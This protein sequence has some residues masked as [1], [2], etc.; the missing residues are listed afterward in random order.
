[1]KGEDWAMLAAAVS[2][3]F[4]AALALSPLAALA[5]WLLQH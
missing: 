2:F 5:Y 1:M 4:V 3:L